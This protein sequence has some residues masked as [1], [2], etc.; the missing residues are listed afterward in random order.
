MNKDTKNVTKTIE[1]SVRLDATPAQLF[2]AY[3]DSR[4][5]SAVTGGEAKMS[6]KAGGGQ[7]R[8]SNLLIVPKKLIVQAWRSSHWKASDPDSILILRFT[9]VPGSRRTGSQSERGR[10]DLT[11]VGVPAHDYKGV[12]QG[13]PKYYWRP[14]K[15][16]LKA[17][18]KK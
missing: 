3:L 14:W 6:R 9:G 5:H 1:Q 7:L 13:W 11:H 15:K 16:Y 4:L 10:I 12:K 18:S 2:D 8:G 17:M